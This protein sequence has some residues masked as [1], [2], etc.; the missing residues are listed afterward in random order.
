[1]PGCHLHAQTLRELQKPEHEHGVSHRSFFANEKMLSN[2]AVAACSKR[3]ATSGGRRQLVIAGL[4]HEPV[5]IS[6]R[7]ATWVFA[8]MRGMFLVIHSGRRCAADVVD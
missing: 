3:Y 2:A 7:M 6:A 4:L 5:D 1:V 8:V